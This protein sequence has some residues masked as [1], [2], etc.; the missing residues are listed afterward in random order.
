MGAAHHIYYLMRVKR[1]MTIIPSPATPPSRWSS[2]WQVVQ[3][4]RP[5]GDAYKLGEAFV[6]IPMQRSR[7]GSSHYR[8]AECNAT[9]VGMY[10]GAASLP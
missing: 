3:A 8:S 7:P 6:P 2:S 5:R 10:P 9:W 4:A 1:I